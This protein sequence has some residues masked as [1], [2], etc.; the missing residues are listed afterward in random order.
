[1]ICCDSAGQL[2]PAAACPLAGWAGTVRGFLPRVSQPPP[3][4]LVAA[5]EQ[6]ECGSGVVRALVHMLEA[7]TRARTCR[8]GRAADTCRL[9]DN[10]AW[11]AGVRVR[12]PIVFKRTSTLCPRRACAS[13]RTQAPPRSSV[14]KSITRTYPL[15]YV[16]TAWADPRVRR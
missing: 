1:M 10:C 8:C 14:R 12:V 15:V 7:C 11:L 16:S 3:S 6:L 5:A 13:M 2:S 9:A 4:I